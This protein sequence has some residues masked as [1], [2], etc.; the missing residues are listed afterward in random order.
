MGHLREKSPV[1][2]KITKK[3]MNKERQNYISAVSVACH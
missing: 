2:G 3:C 1:F